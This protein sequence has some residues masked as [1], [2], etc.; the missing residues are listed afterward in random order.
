MTD[1]ESRK[2]QLGAVVRDRRKGLRLTQEEVAELGGPATA[3]QRKIE[4]GAFGSL[5]LGTTWPLERV[6]GWRPGAIAGFLSNDAQ[7]TIE[8]AVEPNYDALRVNGELP[9]GV[10]LPDVGPGEQHHRPALNIPEEVV[11]DMTSEQITEL[12]ARLVADAWKARR[13]ILGS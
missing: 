4:A 1:Q 10:E 13:E 12:E 6:L 5:R 8:A 7:A 3:T 11:R 2:R 9:A